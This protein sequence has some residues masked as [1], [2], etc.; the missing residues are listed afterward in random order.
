MDFFIETDRKTLQICQRLSE[1]FL[2]KFQIIYGAVI[3]S[4]FKDDQEVV[5]VIIQNVS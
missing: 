1:I 3:L 4:N 5:I 2:R